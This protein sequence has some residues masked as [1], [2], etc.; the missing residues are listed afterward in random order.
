M[1]ATTHDTSALPQ[2]FIEPSPPPYA[3]VDSDDV[4]MPSPGFITDYV[5]SLRGME[6]PSLFCIWSA[7]WTLST[8]SARLSWIDWIPDSPLY[9]NLY[10]FLVAPP[11]RCH[12]ST[13]AVFARRRLQNVPQRIQGDRVVDHFHRY[14]STYNWATSKTTP[15]VIYE[16]LKPQKQQLV[17]CDKTSVADKGSQLAICASELE[18]FINKKKFTVGL[19]GTLTELY[20]CDSDIVIHTMQRGELH[21][22][23][24][25]ITMIG[26]ITTTGMKDSLPPEAYGEGFMSRVIVVFK[27]KTSRRFKKPRFFDGYPTLV[28]L[29][30]RLAF[31][32]SNRMGVYTLSPE[33]DA[34][35]ERWYDR[36]RD[37]IDNDAHR[38]IEHLGENRF[39]VNVLRVGLL[40]AMSRYE[41][42]SR[43]IE[44]EDLK[45]AERL[46]SATYHTS[47][48]VSTE[49][50]LTTE[51]GAE[52]YPKIVAYMRKK[53]HA[54]RQQMTSAMSS[55]GVSMKDTRDALTQLCIE[56][57]LQV[58]NE[59]NTA[60]QCVE[61]SKG[62]SYRW[63][64]IPEVQG[65]DDE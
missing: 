13:A 12:K 33:A 15:D 16:L 25:Y 1:N 48:E 44:V 42:A 40:I 55:K 53:K 60:K 17:G 49:A 8:L 14:M 57:R 65:D 11:G 4:V 41:N 3:Y 24:I 21:L 54:T 23:D 34:W 9:P 61:W 6:T 5:A 30:E 7:L 63:I 19:I 43:T 46:L 2:A 62:E 35:F 31:L 27:E 28:D 10:V 45:Q 50:G 32:L 56:E 47:N 22:K 26:A 38:N 52:H 18:T 64:E 29:E 36:W 39:D 59:D 58:L 51:G 37:Y 20:D